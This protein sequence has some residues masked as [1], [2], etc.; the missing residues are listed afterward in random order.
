MCNY[1]IVWCTR[2][3]L[4]LE[5]KVSFV[6]YCKWINIFLYFSCQVGKTRK[7]WEALLYASLIS[8]TGETGGFLWEA[9]FRN[10]TNP[11][12]SKSIKLQV[13]KSDMGGR[14]CCCCFVLLLS[15][16]FCLTVGRDQEP[17][18]V[19]WDENTLDGAVSQQHSALETVL[20]WSQDKAWIQGMV[21]TVHLGF[22]L[23][24]KDTL[25]PDCVLHVP[26]ICRLV[27]KALA[28][29]CG[30]VDTHEHTCVFERGQAFWF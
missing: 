4:Y 19:T 16:L 3:K 15:W 5:I 11:P 6:L 20:E 13:L 1:V 28:Q 24:P 14:V 30:W 2:W 27:G 22:C 21:P 17:L 29:P 23:T 25:T 9:F 18:N 8:V 26:S 12:K 7:W 10:A